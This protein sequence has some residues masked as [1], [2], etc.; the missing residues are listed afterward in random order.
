MVRKPAKIFCPSV[1]VNLG[2]VANACQYLRAAL[3]SK[4]DGLSASAGAQ[5]KKSTD[6]ARLIARSMTNTSLQR[7]RA[8]VSSIVPKKTHESIEQVE[9]LFNRARLLS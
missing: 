7:F 5:S 4:S 9:N 1:S 2:S 3:A 8:K 6:V